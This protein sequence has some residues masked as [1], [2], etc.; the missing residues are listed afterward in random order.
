MAA[1]TAAT[2]A[3]HV[4]FNGAETEQE[5]AVLLYGAADGIKPQEPHLARLAPPPR[6]PG[7]FDP[8]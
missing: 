6:V 8:D 4:A 7:A 3:Y 2:G 1:K 5:L